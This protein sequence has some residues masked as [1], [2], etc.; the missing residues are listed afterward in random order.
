MRLNFE[1]IIDCRCFGVGDARDGLHLD[2]F[3]LHY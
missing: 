2:I 1:R 3:I